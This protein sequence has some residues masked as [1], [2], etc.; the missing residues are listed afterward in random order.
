MDS[1]LKENI[2]KHIDLSED[3]FKLFRSY[4]TKKK[5]LKKEY[6]LREGDICKYEGFILNGC[7]RVFSLDKNA[8]E[9]TLHFGIKDWWLSDIDSFTN[10]IP[11][12]LFIQALEDSEVLLISWNNKMKAYQELP[13]IE[14]LFRVMTQKYLVANQRRILQKQSLNSE[15]RYNYFLSHYP[16]IAKKLTNIQLASY[17]GI[18][19]EFVS[20]IRSRIS[21]KK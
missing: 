21:T 19:H 8:N 3:E 15:E 14:R 6:L 7:F 10:Q 5:I 1:I 4:F 13:K 2:K 18:S 16:E 11:S 20:K 17:L 12:Q 9:N